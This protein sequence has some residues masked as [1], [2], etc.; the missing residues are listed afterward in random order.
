[1]NLIDYQVTK[2]LSEPKHVQWFYEDGRLDVEYWK[3]EIEYSD[4]GGDGQTKWESFGSEETALAVC[5]G[6]IGQH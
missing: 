1:M 2:V 3:V 5:V 6:Y 4:D